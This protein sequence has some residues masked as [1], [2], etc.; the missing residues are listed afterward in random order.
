M[1]YKKQLVTFDIKKIISISLFMFILPMAFAV[2]LKATVFKSSYGSTKLWYLDLIIYV[3]SILL[4]I[5]AHELIHALGFKIF[6]KAKHKEI[7]FGIAPKQGMVFCTCSKP[8]TAKA[9]LLTLI[10]PIIITGVIPLIIVTIWGNIFWI[11]IFSFMISGGAGDIIMLKEVVKLDKK[12]LVLDHPKAPAFYL[13]YEEGKEPENFIESNA[14]QEKH[15]LED[16][17]KS[18]FENK[19]MGIKI[20]LILL[21]LSISVIVLGLIGI[22]LML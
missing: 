9:Y 18:P 11:I 20:L 3:V 4:L 22:L 14:E 15:L 5:V 19:S 17:N 12:Q 16:M 13:L 1:K 7:K 10:L 21:F 2:L 6:G 8:I